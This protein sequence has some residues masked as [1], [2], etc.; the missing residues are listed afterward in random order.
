M[1]DRVRSLTVVLDRDTRTDD[2]EVIVTAVRMVRGVADVKLGP[3]VNVLDHVAR[4]A[5]LQDLESRVLAVFDEA[6][7]GKS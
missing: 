2:V 1:T 3:V 7:K 6:R 5:A 4:I